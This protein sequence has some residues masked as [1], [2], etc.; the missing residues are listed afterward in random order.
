MRRALLFLFVMFMA[1]A[2]DAR[3]GGGESYSGGGGGSSGGSGDGGGGAEILFYVVRFLFWLTIRHPVIGIP[4]DIVLIVL[5]IRWMKSR[6]GTNIVTFGGTPVTSLASTSGGRLE[7]LRRFDPNFSAITFSDFCYSLYGRAH[8][9]RGEG[10]LD[11]YSPYLSDNARAALRQLSPPGLREVRGIVV[12]AFAVRDVRGLEGPQVIVTVEFESN[13]SEVTAS[14]EENWYARERWMLERQK[15]LLS[16]P[17]EKAKADHCPRCGAAL[18]T[19]TDGSCAYCGVKV[20]SGA[21]QWYV[22]TIMPLTREPRG[23]RLTSNVPEQGTNRRTILQ[24]DFGIRRASFEAEHPAFSWDAFEARVR[25]IATE[26][27]AAWTAREWERVRPLETDSLFQMHRYWIDAYKRQRLRNIVDDHRITSLDPVKIET[28]AFYESITVRI[29]AEGRDYT[30]DDN[31][32][33]VA[34]SREE[35]RVWSE[36]WTFIRTRGAQGGTKQRACPN[37]GAAIAVGATG[38]C[39]WCGGKL[40]AGEFDWVLSRIEQ[41]E[42]YGG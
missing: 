13:Y 7:D 21:F 20:S 29:W 18:D 27:Q 11:R 1:V 3:V 41:D 9:A 42:A 31:G 26:L 36:Y 33:V 40:T 6:N 10:D 17:P 39:P 28:D 38:V 19:R 37:C 32:N 16:P 5:V 34:G 14:G 23:P 30:V 4:V 15:D 35:L 24:P 22:R 2:A 8:N 25:E 12:G